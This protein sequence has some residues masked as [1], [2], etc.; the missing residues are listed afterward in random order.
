VPGA[1]NIAFWESGSWARQDLEALCTLDSSRF[2]L[3]LV[4]ALHR[5]LERNH[6]SRLILQAPGLARGVAGA[7]LLAELIRCAH[8]D[9]VLLLSPGDF[10]ASLRKELRASGIET[11]TPGDPADQGLDKQKRL[12]QRSRMWEGYL[13]NA[14]ETGLSLDD[15]QLLGTPPPIEAPE[16][17]RG[18]QIALSDRGKLIT[19]GQIT[20]LQGNELRARVAAQPGSATQLLVRDALF[21]DGCLQSAKPYRRPPD[22]PREP[23]TAT[24][25][26][27]DITVGKDA[28]CGPVPVARIG[29]ATACLVNGVFGDPLLRL[30]FHHQGR[31]LLFDLGDPGRMAARIA[32]QVTDIFFSHTH[33]DHIG[34]FFWFLRSRIGHLPACRCYGPPGLAEQIAGMVGGILWDRVEDRAPRFEV[35]EWHGDHLRHFR[36][37]AGEKSIEA[38][39]DLPLESGI[40]WREPGFAVRATILD[41]RTP[42]LA[43][44]YEPSAEVKVRRDRLQ[45][46]G[47]KSGRWLQQLKQAYM[48]GKLDTAIT[49]PDGSERSVAQLRDE[50]LLPNPGRKLVYATDFADT[51]KNRERL[52]ELARGAHSLFC[53]ASFMLEHAD[54]AGRTQ[55]LTT[56]ACAEIANAAGVGQLLPFHF[57][58]RYIKRAQDVYREIHQVCE[59]TVLPGFIRADAS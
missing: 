53:E 22:K 52:V 11:L 54:Q 38:L 24:F 40:L 23:P 25:L 16:A 30:Q 12:S 57:S 17:W 51:G 43:Y 21:V 9:T 31:S 1:L 44:A 10:P 18:R 34:G 26:P 36:I 41:H 45:S 56:R 59:R 19:M 5:L 7:E 37:T 2:R 27:A 33:A 42:V 39:G 29:S 28:R 3:P 32:H 47:L 35:R 50:L 58:K 20:S 6:G 4:T 55:H 13:E 15:V 46:M 14:I 8:I 48:Q 49:L